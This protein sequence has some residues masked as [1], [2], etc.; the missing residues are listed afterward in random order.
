[1]N[2]YVAALE[3]N[4]FF[5]PDSWYM[6]FNLNLAFASRAKDNWRL[7]MPVLLLHG[8]YDYVCETMDSSLAEPMRTNC[9]NLVEVVVP[10]GHR[11]AEGKR[12]HVN[13]ALAKWSALQFPA[14]WATRIFP[15]PARGGRERP[16]GRPHRLIFLRRR[17]RAGSGIAEPG[18]RYSVPGAK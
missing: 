11:M 13:A 12:T 15:P 8:E 1:E 3:R 6:N 14:L 17:N 7:M 5:G 4:G 18:R 16:V 9:A 2:A 10:S